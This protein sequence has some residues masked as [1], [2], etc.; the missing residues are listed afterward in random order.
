[1]PSAPLA[2]SQNMRQ[3]SKPRDVVRFED[4]KRL[5]L[6]AA[7][8]VAEDDEAADQGREAAADAQ[9]AA[10]LQRR[11]LRHGGNR[12]GERAQSATRCARGV[13]VHFGGACPSR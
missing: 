12:H 13:V 7:P 4:V 8:E 11:L 5:G 3:S 9:G 2:G 10:P 1:M 6:R